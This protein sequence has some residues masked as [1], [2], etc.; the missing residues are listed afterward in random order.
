MNTRFT[1]YLGTALLVTFTTA[2]CVVPVA[3]ADDSCNRDSKTIKLKIKQK[4]NT[5]TKVTKGFFG[6]NAD[7]VHACH[8][9]TIEWKLS[10]KKFYIEFTNKSPFNKDK[11]T[12]NNGKVRIIISESAETGVRFKY[13]IGID[14]GGVLDPVIIIDR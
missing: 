2:F 3:L 11:E 9:D 6:T 10:G 7:T 14:G 8:G 5:P 1:S 13:D 12:S 4:N